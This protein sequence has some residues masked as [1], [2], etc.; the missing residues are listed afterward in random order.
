MREDAA[1]VLLGTERRERR[2]D[3]ESDG[4][5]GDE[6]EQAREDRG[7]EVEELV[8]AGTCIQPRMA[9]TISAAN[10]KIICFAWPPLR[11]RRASS[12][13]RSTESLLGLDIVYLLS[14]K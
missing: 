1:R 10:H 7:D 5:H 4:R 14:W 12:L 8:E 6:L 13:A 3:G 2:D 9:P 11:W